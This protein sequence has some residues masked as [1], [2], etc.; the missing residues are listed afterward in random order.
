MEDIEFKDE[1]QPLQVE[2]SEQESDNLKHSGFAEADEI[3]NQGSE[4]EP[5]K[6]T[7]SVVEHASSPSQ[8]LVDPVSGWAGR[9]KPTGPAPYA[10][11]LVPLYIYPVSEQTWQPLYQAYVF[12]PS[13]FQKLTNAKNLYSISNNPNYEFVIVV[14]P[15]S[16]PG[17]NAL[18][19]HD[20]MREIPK[21]NNYRNVQTVGYMRIDWC[22]RPLSETFADIETFARWSTSGRPGLYV[23]G[24]YVDETP[25]HF[26]EE[27][28]QYLHAVRKYIRALP[29]FSNR[30]LVSLSLPQPHAG[31]EDLKYRHSG[32]HASSTYWLTQCEHPDLRKSRYTA[33]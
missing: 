22:R 15:N 4:Q 8:Q 32:S 9:I 27:R 12:I 33:R 16:G 17:G 6:H 23:E 3:E 18:P 25:N 14:N 30:R 21:L 20:Y 31:K 11:I 2:S 29:G 5:D 26:T 10:K 1:A 13:S 24:I 7:S 28:A 19:S